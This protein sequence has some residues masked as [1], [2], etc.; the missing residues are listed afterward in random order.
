MENKDTIKSESAKV[1]A[2]KTEKEIAEQVL[3][4]EKK[5]VEKRSFGFFKRFL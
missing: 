2:E 5:V 1:S 3:K 4:D